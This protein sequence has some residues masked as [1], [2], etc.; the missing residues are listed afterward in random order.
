MYLFRM[1]MAGTIQAPPAR[2]EPMYQPD[3]FSSSSAGKF[4]V[5]RP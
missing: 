4:E 3:I 1:T 2:V 5:T